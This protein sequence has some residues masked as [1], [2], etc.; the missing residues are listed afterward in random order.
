MR[1]TAAPKITCVALFSAACAAE[2]AAEEVEPLGGYTLV[3]ADDFDGAAGAPI[4]GSK[5]GHDVGG[6]GWGNNQLEYNSDRTENVRLDGEGRLIIEALREDFEGNR[7][8]SGR[9]LTKGRFALQTGRVEARIKL[10]A[11]SGLWPAFWMLGADIDQ[12]S[13]PACGEIDILELRGE[14]PYT[15]LGTVHGPGYSGAEGISGQYSLRAGT[16]ADDFHDFAVDIDPG[17]IAWMIDGQVF[18][19]VTEGDLPEGA[20]WAFD[21]PFF[22]LLNLAVGGNFVGALDEA[23]LP[24]RVEVEHVR[25]YERDL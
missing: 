7:F 8:T 4:D 14:E 19:T 12:V 3:W 13:W 24:A 21:R 20:A 25:V 22:L 9:V 10:P 5:W 23:A 16:F 6:D 11:G 2:P 1:P 15:T 18:H 17:H